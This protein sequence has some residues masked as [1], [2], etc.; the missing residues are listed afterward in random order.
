MNAITRRVAAATAL[1]A[2][3]VL[4]TLG[5]A[6]TSHADST[7]TTHGS[8]ISTSPVQHGA[9]PHQNNTPKPGTPEHHRHQNN[10]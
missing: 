10:R 8:S 6:G 5:A 9:F 3:P 4:I 1:L 2:A 7:V